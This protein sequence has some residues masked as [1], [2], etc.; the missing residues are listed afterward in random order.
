MPDTLLTND[1]PAVELWLIPPG[2]TRPGSVGLVQLGRPIKL[3]SPTDLAGRAHARCH[4][5]GVGGAARP[6]HRPGDRGRQAFE[7]LRSPASVERIGRISIASRWRG[8]LCRHS[9]LRSR[10]VRGA[11]SLCIVAIAFVWLIERSFNRSIFSGQTDLASQRP[12]RMRFEQRDEAR[13]SCRRCASN[14]AALSISLCDTKLAVAKKYHS[15]CT[16]ARLEQVIVCVT[17]L[18]IESR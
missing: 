2:G 6:A 16:V 4:P 15:T 14:Y 18:V 1:P 3:K 13:E 5:R 11:G 9:W 10:I 17:E 12:E 8:N 7:S